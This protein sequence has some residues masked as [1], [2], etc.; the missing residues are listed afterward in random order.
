MNTGASFGE[1]VSVAAASLRSSKLRSSLTLL[2]LIL[3]TT[4]LIAVMSVVRGMDL[5]VADAISNMG[6]DGF[7]VV[8]LAMIGNYDPKK[9]MEGEDF[10]LVPRDV[11]E[12]MN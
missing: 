8:R 4:T 7:R 1:A 10:P 11:I 2:G 5:Y 6:A 3:A 9:L 12:L